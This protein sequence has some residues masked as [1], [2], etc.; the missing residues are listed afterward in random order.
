MRSSAVVAVVPTIGV[1]NC[2]NCGRCPRNEIIE[3]SGLTFII[4]YVND[5]HAHAIVRK[6]TKENSVQSSNEKSGFWGDVIPQKATKSAVT[7]HL[8][9]GELVVL[10][11]EEPA[12]DL[13][14]I[15]HVVAQGHPVRLVRAIESGELVHVIT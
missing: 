14:E 2:D 3:E 11:V 8:P 15:G 9:V 5:V 6:T 4:F 1:V 12:Q 7:S 10:F 13:L